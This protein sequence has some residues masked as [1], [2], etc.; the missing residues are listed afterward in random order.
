MFEEVEGQLNSQQ[1]H[2]GP[3]PAPSRVVDSLPTRSYCCEAANKGSQCYICL[4]EYEDGELVRTLPCKH[5]FHAPC[6]DKWLKDVHRV[7]PLC[8][9]S[10]CEDTSLPNSPV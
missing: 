8:R 6:I 10:I 4:S 1:N 5:E 2:N 7:C 3:H 9:A